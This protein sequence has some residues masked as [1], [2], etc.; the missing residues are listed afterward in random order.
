ML[1]GSE[2]A[3]PVLLGPVEPLQCA[4]Q[5]QGSSGR[6]DSPVLLEDEGG[7][8]WQLRSAGSEA[9]CGAQPAAR[10]LAAARDFCTCLPVTQSIS[11]CDGIRMAFDCSTAWLL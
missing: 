1:R 10:S 4:A 3:Q 2:H 11:S 7:F 8:P 5:Q 9:S 6:A